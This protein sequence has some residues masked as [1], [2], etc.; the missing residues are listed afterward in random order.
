MCVRDP[1][2]DERLMFCWEPWGPTLMPTSALLQTVF[3]SLIYQSDLWRPASLNLRDLLL[4]EPHP[5]AHLQESGGVQALTV[6]ARFDSRMLKCGFFFSLSCRTPVVETSSDLFLGST[7]F[8][9]KLEKWPK[10]ESGTIDR[11][12]YLNQG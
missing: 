11:R 1:L 2:W 7:Q 10:R 6:Q 4:Q 3:F 12:F 8:G 5:T 9:I